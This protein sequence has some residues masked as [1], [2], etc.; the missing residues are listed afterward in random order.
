[1]DMQ[2]KLI[3]VEEISSGLSLLPES[4]SARRLWTVKA[5]VGWGRSPSP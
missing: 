4:N 3:Q 1:M 5:L 2:L